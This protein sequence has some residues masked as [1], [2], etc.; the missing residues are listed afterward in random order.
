[1]QAHFT[2]IKVHIILSELFFC[3]EKVKINESYPDRINVAINY[4][5]GK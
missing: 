2:Y 4:P 5:F 3:N 1:M